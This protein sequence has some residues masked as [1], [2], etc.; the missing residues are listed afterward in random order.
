MAVI[1]R[2]FV[3][4]TEHMLIFGPQFTETNLYAWID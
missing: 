3:A 2:L 4:A 1:Y